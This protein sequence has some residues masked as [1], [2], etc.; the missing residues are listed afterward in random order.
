M[1]RLGLLGAVLAVA[2]CGGDGHHGGETSGSETPSNPSASSLGGTAAVGAA[3]QAGT[4]TAEC[5]DGSGFTT[6]VTTQADGS[7]SGE[8]GSAA[9][10]CVLTVTGGTPPVTLR[11][12]CQP[13]RYRQY[14]AD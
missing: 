14:H 2:G 13:G 8:V 1:A 10:P 6:P 4:V 11:G 12:Y 7:W 3:I 5:S 9:L